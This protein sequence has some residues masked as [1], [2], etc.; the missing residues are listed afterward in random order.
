MPLKRSTDYFFWLEVGSYRPESIE[1][2]PV[3]LPKEHLPEEAKLQVVLCPFEGSIRVK[4]QAMVGELQLMENGEVVALRQPVALPDKLKE[5]LMVAAHL[6]FPVQT[7]ER[8]GTYPLRCNIYY[9]QLLVQSRTIRA[10]VMATPKK[11]KGALRS[12]LDYN[13]TH[14][15]RPEDLTMAP[16]RLS[17]M[18]NDNGNGTHSFR[19]F[20]EGDF[21]S[22]AHLDAHELQDMIRQARGALRKAAWGDEEEW[23]EGKSYRYDGPLEPERLRRDLVRL[24][25]PGH[26]FYDHMIDSLAG[27]GDVDQLNDLMRTPG[28]VQVAFE[29]SE[30]LL[31]PASLIYDRPLDTS[32]PKHDLCGAFSKALDGQERLEESP[33]FL[34]TCPTYGQDHIVCPSG[35]WGFRHAMGMPISIGKSGSVAQP[36]IIHGDS[37]EMVMGVFKGFALLD[38]H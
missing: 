1:E 12:T 6:F 38:A 31:I 37:P 21:V 24:A 27:D 22:N 19:F 13:L 28:L 25:I 36:T 2:T 32:L 29:S 11:A 34:G 30:R 23:Q 18:L 3:P 33:C 16:H 17:V 8:A 5:T 10:R 9:N 14:A 35:F 7:P 4:E 26:R 15:L 20:G